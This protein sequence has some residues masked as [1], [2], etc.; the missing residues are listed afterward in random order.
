MNR[1][2]EYRMPVSLC[3]TQ[4][5][6]YRRQRNINPVTCVDGLFC[7]FRPASIFVTMAGRSTGVGSDM[8]MTLRRLLMFFAAL[9]ALSACSP[10]TI[11]NATI[12]EDGFTVQS[13]IRF[14]PE[15]RHALD[16]YVPKQATGPLPI[17]VFF[18]GGSWRVGERANYLFAA[19][20]L[21]SRGYVAI[22]PDYRLFPDVRFPAFVEDGAKAVRWVL[23]HV[24]DFGGDPD[25]LFLMGHSA[26]AHIAAMLTLDESYLAAEGVPVNSIRGM[27]ALAGPYAF[28]PSRTASVAPI[29]AHLADENEARPIVFVDGDEAPM[30]L[31]HGEDDDTVFVFNTVNLSKAVRD[32]GG[33]ARQ[34]IYPG[35]GHLGILFALATPFRDI[36]PV[37]SDAATFIDGQR[38]LNQLSPVTPR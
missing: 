14:G 7:L 10:F 24:A 26:G 37:L 2:R 13:G 28:Y 6:F 22:V 20:A 5:A 9:F 4:D 3:A 29:F 19:G 38:S 25:R 8:R 11:L 21:A 1:R 23:D 31:L 27:I 12:D 15:V 32:A 35:V 18:Y 36:A 16:V 33:S 17:V 34:I 30:L